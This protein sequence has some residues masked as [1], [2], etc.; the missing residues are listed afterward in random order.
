MNCPLKEMQI[1]RRNLTE[2]NYFTQLRSKQAKENTELKKTAVSAYT[3]AKYHRH[4]VEKQK[5]RFP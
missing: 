4:C 2:Y 3:V 5:K 1:L